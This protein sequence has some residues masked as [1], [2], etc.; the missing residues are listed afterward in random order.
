MILRH[1]ASVLKIMLSIASSM[2]LC[3]RKLVQDSA[4]EHMPCA[5]THENMSCAITHDMCRLQSLMSTCRVQSLM[6]ICRVQSLMS[7]CRVQSLTEACLALRRSVPSLT[8]V[9]LLPPLPLRPSLSLWP[10]NSFITLWPWR[11]TARAN[12][13][14]VRHGPPLPLKME[15]LRIECV[16]DSFLHQR[17]GWDIHT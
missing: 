9:P 2:P 16:T 14:H 10:R 3:V 7:T 1:L 13:S 4:H 12:T 5:I 11:P 17:V 6:S 8:P 15:N